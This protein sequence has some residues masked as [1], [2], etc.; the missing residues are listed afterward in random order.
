VTA[1][2]R[3]R[4]RRSV[5]DVC[6]APLDA[7]RRAGVCVS[8]ACCPRVL[9][10]PALVTEG[11]DRGPRSGPRP[12]HQSGAVIY[13]GRLSGL[14]VAP[15][16]ALRPGQSTAYAVAVAWPDTP[17]DDNPYQGAGLSFTLKIAATQA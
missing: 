16:A 17:A 12:D 5:T 11:V 14:A 8:R 4:K 10:R 2:A 13:Q 9:T 15:R 1:A 7:W 3:R 6:V